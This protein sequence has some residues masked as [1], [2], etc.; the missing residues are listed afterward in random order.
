MGASTSVQSSSENANYT[1][2]SDF[3]D[4]DTST[5]SR[6]VAFVLESN[7]AAAED[8]GTLIPESEKRIAYDKLRQYLGEDNAPYSRQVEY[9][10]QCPKG[11]PLVPVVAHPSGFSET[12]AGTAGPSSLQCSLTTKETL[13]EIVVQKTTQ[14]SNFEWDPLQLDFR[15]KHKAQESTIQNDMLRTACADGD[16]DL[17]AK[18]LDQNADVNDQNEMGVTPLHACVFSSNLKVA[19]FLISRGADQMQGDES[20]MAPI[21]Y[22]AAEGAIELVRFFVECAGTNIA[23]LVGA[24]GITPAHMAANIGNSDILSYISETCGPEYCHQLDS[25]GNAPLHLA[26]SWGHTDCVKILL[27]KGCN[28]N[29]RNANQMTPLMVAL[30]SGHVNPTLAAVR[31]LLPITEVLDKDEVCI[32]QELYVGFDCAVS[33]SKD[34]S[35]DVV[36]NKQT[37][38]HIA[39]LCGSISEL[40]VLL[41]AGAKVDMYDEQGFSPF[42]YACIKSRLDM[43]ALMVNFG[44]HE[45]LVT[46][47]L[48]PGM[49]SPL[50]CAISANS[51]PLVQY[52]VSKFPSWLE[53]RDSKG[54]HPLALALDCSCSLELVRA[55]VVGGADLNAIAKN[56]PRPSET[57][58]HSAMA[59][60][61]SVHEYASKFHSDAATFVR[62]TGVNPVIEQTHWCAQ[63]ARH[64]GIWNGLNC[65]LVHQAA[66]SGRVPQLQELL[67][68]R[69]ATSDDRDTTGFTAL[70]AACAGG[71][72]SIV[73]LL[74]K[75]KFVVDASDNKAGL[76]PLFFAVNGGFPIIVERLMPLV[77]NASTLY[78]AQGCSLLSFLPDD[79]TKAIAISKTIL[80]VFPFMDDIVE[81]VNVAEHIER[82]RTAVQSAGSHIVNADSVSL[83]D[84]LTRLPL[85]IHCRMNFEGQ[86]LLH[87][88]CER[89]EAVMCVELLCR[90]GTPVEA[91]MSNGLSALHVAALHKNLA[92]MNVVLSYGASVDLPDINGITPLQIAVIESHCEGIDLLVRDWHAET[93]ASDFKFNCQC[94]A[95]CTSG[96]ASAISSIVVN[97]CAVPE[98]F[99]DQLNKVM[100]ASGSENTTFICHV[101][102]TA[103]SP[104]ASSGWFEC[105]VEKCC[106]CYRLCKTCMSI[107]KAKESSPTSTLPKVSELGNISQNPTMPFV[108]SSK[109]GLLFDKKVRGVC[110]LC[111][112]VNDTAGGSIGFSSCIQDSARRSLQAFDN[113]TSMLSANQTTNGFELLQRCI[114]TVKN[115][116]KALFWTKL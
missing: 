23:G 88:A 2:S 79:E 80:S 29:V 60:K 18:L 103:T 1:S 46:S 27:Q 5:D 92:A 116:K 97:A 50:I 82:V 115:W 111:S 96:D 35:S 43:V 74:L 105:S 75:A 6:E 24:E 21:H 90:V 30:K 85:L 95:S 58:A 72:L 7:D 25:A 19:Q 83:S 109:S 100:V 70:H 9:A 13:L 66:F 64:A 3:D 71:L 40:R 110:A 38:M 54:T 81:N 4:Y 73:D 67:R 114:P 53:I 48:K 57:H 11:H 45:E 41:F 52:L 77:L 42:H 49:G 15:R 101:C 55:L 22:A 61:V 91:V 47:L 37:T 34:C 104:S 68:I 31:L 87:M 86:T 36:E 98:V 33:I 12:A 99:S 89:L 84:L 26:S 16:L 69:G 59:Q 93:N 17:V 113:R 94:N 20:E 8:A 39:A 78:D 28:P 108:N 106:N 107:L 56:V 62:I 14:T 63:L 10:Y 112:Y 65:P 44:N 32:P 102:L 76:S 51:F